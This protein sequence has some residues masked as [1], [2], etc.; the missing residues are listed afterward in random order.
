MQE[1]VQKAAKIVMG[2]AIGIFIGR[3]AWL[4]QDVN[5]HPELYAMN[6]APWYYRLIV[7]GLIT[8]GVLAVGGLVYWLAGRKQK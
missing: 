1:K 6:S 8:A 2:A 3:S 4:W 5:A 7:E